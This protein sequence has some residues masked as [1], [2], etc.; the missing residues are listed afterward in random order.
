MINIIIRVMVIGRN[1]QGNEVEKKYIE[2]FRVLGK[3]IY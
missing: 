1:V 3:F 2:G